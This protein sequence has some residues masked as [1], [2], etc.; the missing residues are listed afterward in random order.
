MKLFAY[1][2]RTRLLEEDNRQIGAS[3][4]GRGEGYNSQRVPLQKDREGGHQRLRNCMCA[5]TSDGE[6]TQRNGNK[7][8]YKKGPGATLGCSWKVGTRGWGGEYGD[9]AGLGM[10]EAISGGLHGFAVINPGGEY[11]EE[12]RAERVLEGGTKMGGC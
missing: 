10:S 12:R 4:C 5:L 11:W 8:K 7:K 2:S 3:C 1:E 6:D 9:A